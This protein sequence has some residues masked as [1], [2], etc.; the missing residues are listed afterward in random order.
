LKNLNLLIEENATDYVKLGE[1]FEEREQL[2]SQLDGLYDSWGEQVETEEP[3]ARKK[4]TL[5]LIFMAACWAAS[6]YFAYAVSGHRMLALVFAGLGI[7][8]LLFILLDRLGRSRKRAAGV[9]KA[10]L[11]VL[12]LTGFLMFAAA[13]VAVIKDAKTDSDPKADYLIVLGAGLNGTAPSVSLQ[14]RLDA[15]YK[16]LLEYPESVAIVS[17]GRGPG[18]DITEAEAMRAYLIS[19]EISPDRIIMEEQ[20]ASTIENIE[21]SIKKI[22][23]A[24]G[25]IESSVAI[26]SSEYLL[27]RAKRIARRFGI[28]P[29]V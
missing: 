10:I 24:G 22:Y 20:A 17:G 29:S 28:D 21:Y 5:R 16:Y 23:E 26:L 8:I 12:L 15:A 9:L 11:S 1:L 27:C 3:T 7:L 25:T 6:L 19:R 14:N 18:E 2:E 4:P 13:E